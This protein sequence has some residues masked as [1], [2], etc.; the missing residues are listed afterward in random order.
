MPRS[1]RSSATGNELARSSDVSQVARA[2]V[3]AVMAT[4]TLLYARI[5]NLVS[6]IDSLTLDF[7]NDPSKYTKGVVR[8]F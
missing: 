5:N 4:D 1:A 7:K 3:Q 2:N 6:R 8:I